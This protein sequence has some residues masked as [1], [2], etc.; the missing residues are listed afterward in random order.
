M[1]LDLDAKLNQFPEV[2]LSDL[3]DI[4]AVFQGHCK[5]CKG[6]QKCAKILWICISLNKFI[7]SLIYRMFLEPMTV[8]NIPMTHLAYRYS[9]PS[10]PLNGSDALDA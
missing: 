6:S 3:S 10:A 4:F 8:V 5:H 7:I 2:S 9:N 1:K